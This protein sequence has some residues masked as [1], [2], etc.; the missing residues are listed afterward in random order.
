MDRSA[1]S[2]GIS[3]RYG[4]TIEALEPRILFS[5]DSPAVL[6]A[7]PAPIALVQTLAPAEFTTQATIATQQHGA[8]ELVVIDARVQDKPE[9]IADLTAQREQGRRIDWLVLD[10]DRNGVDQLSETLTRYRNLDTVHLV[11]HAADGVL[12]LGSTRFDID[13]VRQRSAD[14]AA[15]GQALGTGGDLLI[16]GC[17]LAAS[18][19]GT[20]LL[21]ALSSLTGV[22]LAASNDQT[23]STAFGGDWVLEQEIGTI[24]SQLAFSSE[25]QQHWTGTLNV[26]PQGAEVRINNVTLGTQALSDS[27]GGNQIATFADGSFVVVW[28]VSGGNNILA[29]RFAVDG[30]ALTGDIAVNSDTSHIVSQAV[31]AVDQGSGRFV[32]AWTNDGLDGS[33]N[34]VYLRVFDSAGMVVSGADARVNPA[35]ALQQSQPA[36]AVTANGDA[37]I[38]YT[39]DT[40]GSDATDNIY[41]RTVNIRTMTW[42]AGS[43]LVN[44][45]GSDAKDQNNSSVAVD[46][47]GR[48]IVTWQSKSQD[49]GST[50]GVYARFFDVASKTTV[51]S[52]F[53][54]N[55]LTVSN[56]Y[57]PTVSANNAGQ[58]VIGWTDDLLNEGVFAQLFSSAAARVGSAT[59]VNPVAATNQN[60][61]SVAMLASGG[62]VAVWQSDSEVPDSSGYGVFARQFDAS[63]NAIQGEQ[64]VNVTTG[65]N[66]V[67]PGLVV[68]GSSGR[69]IWN[70]NGPG[71]SNGIF[72]RAFE[73][74]DP[75]LLVSSTG[76]N[77]TTESGALSPLRIELAT[78]PT[79]SVSVNLSTSDSSEGTPLTSVL[80]FTTAN[81]NVAQ[82]VTIRGV[83]DAIVDGTVAYQISVS[84]SSADTRYN[85]LPV[86]QVALSNYDND[87][88]NALV[89][90]TDAD[91]L[92]GDTSSVFS[93]MATR[94]GDG[95]ISLREAIAATNN[96]VNSASGADLI[97]FDLI[98]AS[99][100][101]DLASALPEIT[102]RV[103]IDATNNVSNPYVDR[104]VITLTTSS[105]TVFDGLRLANSAGG[106][107]IIGLAI[108]GFGGNGLTVQGAANTL[109]QNYIGVRPDGVTAFGNGG[110]GINFSGAA[111]SLNSNVVRDNVVSAN[112]G[113]G[114]LAIN[115]SLSEFSG[116]R[117]GVT[118]DGLQALGNGA[119]GIEIGGAA[120]A[121][122]IFDNI[123]GANAAAG[124]RLIGPNVQGTTIQHNWVGTDASLTRN[125]GNGDSAITIQDGAHDN[126]IGGVSNGQGNFIFHT[127]AKAGVDLFT[128]FGSAGTGNAILGNLIDD[129]TLGIRLAD[130]STSGWTA[131][132]NDIDDSDLGVNNR[133]NYP[134]LSNATR[135]S[136]SQ[137]RL[138]GA[139]TSLAGQFFRIEFFADNLPSASGHGDAPIFLGFTHLATD[140]SGDANFDIVLNSGVSAGARVTATATR[141]NSNFTS[142]SD[143]SEFAA[144]ISANLPPVWANSSSA[145][146]TENQ[147]AVTS[148]TA[149]DPMGGVPSFQII[150]GADA[151]LFYIDA[152]NTL[153]FLASPNFEAP[154]DA[155]GNNYY[156]LTLRAFG[157]YG[158][159]TDLG[160]SV[161]VTDVNEAPVWI[162]S[163]AQ[164]VTENSVGVVILAAS[165]P[166]ALA[167]MPTYVVQGGLDAARF[168]IVNGDTLRFVTA[169]DYEQPLDTNVDNVYQLVVRASE[170]GLNYADQLFNVTVSD[171]ADLAP[172]PGVIN[173]A[174]RENQIVIGDLLAS[175]PVA[176]IVPVSYTI[177][178]GNDAARFVL[179]AAGVLS[180]QSAPDFESPQDSDLDNQYEVQ[181][182]VSDRISSAL[183]NY[184]VA[185]SDANEAP[186]IDAPANAALDE[187]ASINFSQ[188]TGLLISLSDPDVFAAPVTVT[189]QADHGLVSLTQTFGL[190]LALG[191]AGPSS[192]LEFSGSFVDVNQA[193]RDLRFTAESGYAGSAALRLMVSD[194]S[195]GI[196]SDSRTI[197]LSIRAVDA[198]PPLLQNLG[199]QAG[200]ADSMTAQG[201]VGDVSSSTGLLSTANATGSQ[202]DVST[203][204]S[205]LVS[206]STTVPVTPGLASAPV[207]TSQ[208]GSTSGL[209]NGLPVVP[210]RA[211][212]RHNGL[213]GSD[214]RVLEPAGDDSRALRFDSASR[215]LQ[216]F[217]LRKD[218]GALGSSVIDTDATRTSE[219]ALLQ[220]AAFRND[221]DRVREQVTS[222]IDIERNLLASSVAVSAGVSI[223]YVIWLIR[224][225]VLLSSLLASIPA[226][227]AIDPLPILSSFGGDKGKGKDQGQDADQDEEDDSL[228]AMLKK[229]AQSTP[230]QAGGASR[231]S[232]SIEADA[233]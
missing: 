49:F 19:A 97:S 55:T 198:S 67:N 222:R 144:N 113:A 159:W 212:A 1:S 196:L 72:S 122:L 178:G 166:D 227:S 146:Q 210:T 112:G 64:L 169:P 80:T 84:S 93:L 103:T 229:A 104:P 228:Q 139:L 208:A 13:V 111:G 3:R 32:V 75:A 164:S 29:R 96:T 101:L 123:I 79:A 203:T 9:L 167:Q 26:V 219:R 77:Y 141:S 68:T 4:P 38:T 12:Q 17:D 34:G 215:Y 204:V 92:D 143:S 192:S 11:S 171:A 44:A 59:I 42:S 224:G 131:L 172:L 51:G 129:S 106:S 22:D 211:D 40:S 82:S 43:Y 109:E 115:V 58:F 95:K 138:S 119:A 142:F 160:L 56:Q 180:F 102:D 199:V 117:I 114:V 132:A 183:R 87:G 20:Q 140:S 150:G 30:T 66:Q 88:V 213:F 16:Y 233:R 217:D 170:P 176:P 74:I 184:S 218:S 53:I 162:S 205:T 201:I 193:I 18:A 158:D 110:V 23:A 209:A 163:P 127:G 231:N 6:L 10:T 78:M 27:R 221:L 57:N 21:D 202:A 54:A 73:F 145:S 151:A 63:G 70:G 194:L 200:S 2:R 214:R 90:D 41:A 39:G 187:N 220:Q 89:V 177:I 147:T 7:I 69:I 130:F 190:A 136:A 31:V 137:T 173:L 52:E 126:R 36:V 223:G 165:D 14:I 85:S 230:P 125:L 135:V 174:A 149:T 157:Q 47:S 83:D 120:S 189:I 25:L 195:D 60:N 128:D 5:A 35:G 179:N 186:R 15:W 33:G 91:L 99:A 182:M 133:Q 71:D 152:G 225:G 185:L 76:P 207:R 232:W 116:N 46:G 161:R 65:N 155:G 8:R 28:E 181:V 154:G 45:N 108:G 37:I 156:D 175:E 121:N 134:V 148:L 50:W 94:G 188:S 197:A 105:A 226:W 81:W 48:A 86:T 118:A 216:L 191:A 62:Y 206:T 98:G 153:N 168:I 24:E 107:R 100:I 124:I 61:A